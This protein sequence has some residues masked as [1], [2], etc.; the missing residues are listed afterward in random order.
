MV[1]HH[2]IPDGLAGREPASVGVRSI[3]QCSDGHVL[4]SPPAPLREHGV[5][6]GLP[7]EPVLPRQH[8]R[9]GAP[10]AF[11]TTETYAV[12]CTRP[13]RRRRFSTS[14]PSRVR[15]RTLKPWVFLRYRVLG[16][17]VR[18]GIV[19]RTCLRAVTAHEPEASLNCMLRREYS[20]PCK[21]RH[22]EDMRPRPANLRRRATAFVG[23]TAS[24][25][26]PS[27]GRRRRRSRLP[28]Q[29]EDGQRRCQPEDGGGLHGPVA[30]EHLLRRL[31][32]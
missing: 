4:A 16:W 23:R 9:R 18:F 28:P 26:T 12:R 13:L 20:I 5:K 19:H 29:R 10:C 11:A 2:R 21:R 15:I 8:R 32:G 6:A 30:Q 24:G 3:G 27:R 31:P 17:N 7:G 14:L 25:R 1:A 22:Y